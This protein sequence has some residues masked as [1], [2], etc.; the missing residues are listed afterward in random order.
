[1]VW[2]ACSRWRSSSTPAASRS[3]MTRRRRASRASSR[4]S[5]RRATRRSPRRSEVSLLERTLAAASA[6][7]RGGGRQR[8]LRAF[9]GVPPRRRAPA[10]ATVRPAVG[11]ALVHLQA[12][13]R[14]PHSV[15][16][17]LLLAATVVAGRPVA[18]QAV[19]R[20]A[21]RIVGIDLLVTLAAAGAV[22]IGE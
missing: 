7:R 13:G 20:L 15:G 10:V 5:P 19:R 18:V 17:G 16:L 3:F 8:S 22:V 12:A 4:P 21:V 1:A 11:S 9:R 2:W 6:R 14:R